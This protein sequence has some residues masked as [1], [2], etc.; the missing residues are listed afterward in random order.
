MGTL[1]LCSKS[2]LAAG[3]WETPIEQLL[4]NYRT[5][6]EQPI[7]QRREQPI[8][9]PI[10]QLPNALRVPDHAYKQKKLSFRYNNCF[11]SFFFEY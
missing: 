11:A 5:T 7:E 2:F 8:E 10:E 1:H 3:R 4:N 9:Q 6:I